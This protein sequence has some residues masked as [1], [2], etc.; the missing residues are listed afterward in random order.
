MRK[1]ICRYPGDPEVEVLELSRAE[2]LVMFPDRG[3]RITSA[4]PRTGVITSEYFAAPADH[5]VCDL[6]NSDP[7]EMIYLYAGNHGYCKKCF[8]E[9]IVKYCVPVDANELTRQGVPDQ[10]IRDASRR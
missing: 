7:R 4:D 10:P 6:C 9:G 1:M 2:F 8:E 3:T 5:I